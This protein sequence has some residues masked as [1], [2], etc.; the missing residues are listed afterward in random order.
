VRITVYFFVFIN[1]YN[2]NRTLYNFKIHIS[3]YIYRT[4]LHIA[5]IN[6]AFFL[7]KV[8]YFIKIDNRISGLSDRGVW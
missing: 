3:V 4:M 7:I 6:T 5:G 1:G 8:L 2:R